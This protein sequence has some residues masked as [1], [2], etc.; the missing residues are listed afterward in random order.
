[1]PSAARTTGN[2]IVNRNKE[3]LEPR[4]KRPRYTRGFLWTDEDDTLSPTVQWSLTAKPLPS[5]PSKEYQNQAAVHTIDSNPHLFEII[6]PIKV[7]R[8]QELLS[9]HPN[10]PTVR[11]VCRSLRD[12]F[13]P[14]AN[15][16]HETY[17]VTWDNSHRPIKT[18]AERN[19]LESQIDKEV[20]AGRYS[21]DFGPEL[22][23]GMYCSPIHTVPKPGTDTFRLINDQ[24]H[25]EFSPN[26]MID[27]DDIAGTCM[28]GIKSLGASLRAYRRKHGDHVQLIMHKSDIQ[29]AYRNIPMAP[30]WQLKQIV[31][32]EHRKHVDRCNCFGC[33][34]SYYVYLAFISFVCWIAL[35]VKNIQHLKC[36]IDDNCSFARL[37][38]VKYYP[39]YRRYFPTDQTKLL[40]LW[41]ELGLP[42]EEKKQIY[43]PIIP[44]IGF[45]VDPNAMTVSIND[46]RKHDLLDKVRDFA[47]SGK[48]RSLKD[49]QSIAGHINW[50]LAVFPL[51]KPGLSAVYAKMANKTKTMASIR[52][53]NAVR[54]ELLW[55]AKHA[56][57]SDGIFLLK[58][59]AWDPSDDLSDT[60]ICLADASPDGMAYWYPEFNL[61]FQCPVSSD[62]N[63]TNSFY[64]D[65]LAVTSAILD[66]SHVASKMVIY[67]DNQKTV[68]VWHSLSA[69]APYNHLLM[70]GID[71]LVRFKIDA[72]V[73]HIPSA[74][75]VVANALSHFNN[76]LALRLAPGLE[77]SSFLP[78][79]ST[80]G[81]SKK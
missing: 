19:F 67:S 64:F 21:D 52:V 75:N 2:L 78:P 72:R 16:H 18:D 49:F 11:S 17:P 36:Y 6:T 33:R 59:V 68:D 50:S 5:V 12:G 30:M 51:L 56:E 35:H 40:E 14:C 29:G 23:P 39:K 8:F 31:A 71:E 10:Q 53:N 37:G 22:L 48:R 32:F 79:H 26:S 42:H 77:I 74:D 3:A 7:N 28:D 43:G 27:R 45:D 34:G 25:G 44:F 60:T 69:S 24:S 1:M 73:V 15:T 62:P 81:A 4:A 20:A 61:G 13:W 38:D 63:M 76:D 41:D 47:K 9:R 80:L 46:E 66:N 70:L 57:N 55:F 58:S 65:A 54:D